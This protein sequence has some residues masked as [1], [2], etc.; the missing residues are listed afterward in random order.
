MIKQSKYLINDINQ[1]II[2]SESI[3]HSDMVGSRN[4]KSAGTVV[5]IV[6]DDGWPDCQVYGESLVLGIGNNGQDDINI[7]REEILG[8]PA[9]KAHRS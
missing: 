2:F 5:F 7:I 4:T 3:N 9:Y 6:G 8:W 1:V